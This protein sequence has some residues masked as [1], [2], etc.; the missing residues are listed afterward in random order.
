MLTNIEG[1]E[2]HYHAN[3]PS[4]CQLRSFPSGSVVLPM[5][6]PQETWVWSLNQEDPLEEA[7]WK[8]Q[9]TPGFL[10]GKSHGQRSLAGH[11]AWDH[12]V[13]H[14]W[15][16]SQSVSNEHIL[17]QSLG[18]QYHLPIEGTR[19][20]METVDSRTGAGN[21]QDNPRTS[22]IGRG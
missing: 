17:C 15:V 21:T 1:K 9:P 6:A 13:R 5:Q 14:D 3:I 11:S 10:P 4:F 19:L 16:H 18:F 20:L 7:T 8:W 22:R 12:R 2:R